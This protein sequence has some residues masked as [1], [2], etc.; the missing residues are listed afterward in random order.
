VLVGKGRA[1][2]AI[3]H[4]RAAADLAPS[5]PEPHYQLSLAYRKL[6]RKEE[7]EA[8]S[9]VVKKIHESRRGSVE[10]NP[11]PTPDR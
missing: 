2:D 3:A 1:T 6:G 7:A 4:L 5:N 10:P 9:A 11:S 8:E